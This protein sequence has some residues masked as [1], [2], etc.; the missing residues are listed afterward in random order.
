MF[1]TIKAEALDCNPITLRGLNGGNTPP[2]GSIGWFHSGKH[3]QE[4]FVNVQVLAPPCRADVPELSALTGGVVKWPHGTLLY[5]LT[6]RP[7]SKSRGLL[8][9]RRPPA[10]GK[11]NVQLW[12]QL[13]IIV[14]RCFN[15]FTEPRAVSGTR[16]RRPEGGIQT[17]N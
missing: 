6:P 7:G 17:G 9:N 8:G 11:V 5:I 1:V 10:P 12:I 13:W 3:W 16:C 4:N 14:P 15:L 2:P